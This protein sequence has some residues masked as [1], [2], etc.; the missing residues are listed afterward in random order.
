M[1]LDHERDMQQSTVELS[2]V[3]EQED[4]VIKVRMESLSSIESAIVIRYA[5]LHKGFNRLS[6]NLNQIHDRILDLSDFAAATHL[7]IAGLVDNARQVSTEILDDDQ[8]DEFEEIWE[9]AKT[10]DTL[11]EEFNTK[12]SYT[13][14]G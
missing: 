5:E 9:D 2:E 1:K 11:T 7:V 14:G 10:V 13:S 12:L 4:P 8:T 6:G 3:L